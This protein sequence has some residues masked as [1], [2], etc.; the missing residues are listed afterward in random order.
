MWH[1]TVNKV[2]GTDEEKDMVEEQKNSYD[3]V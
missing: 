3:V 2:T 1:D